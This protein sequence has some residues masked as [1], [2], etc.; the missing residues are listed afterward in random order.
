MQLPI[1][2]GCSQ[3]LPDGETAS[4]DFAR[5]AD[6]VS[7]IR[8]SFLQHLARLDVLNSAA[9]SDLSV[10]LSIAGPSEHLKALRRRLSREI[11]DMMRPQR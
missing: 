7:G 5:E 2:A 9:C 3:R 4:I 6:S 11:R 10:A 8:S 1:V